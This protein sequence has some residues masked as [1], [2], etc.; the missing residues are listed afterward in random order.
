[1][2]LLTRFP[3]SN[4]SIIVNFKRLPVFLVCGLVLV[5]AILSPITALQGIQHPMSLHRD[6]VEHFAIVV[7]SSCSPFGSLLTCVE[8]KS[9]AVRKTSNS[10]LVL[11]A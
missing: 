3:E 11:K 2:A 9:M 8:I 10:S 5:F 1:M 4:T 7:D 6:S